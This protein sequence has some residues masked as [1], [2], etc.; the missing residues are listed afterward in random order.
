MGGAQHPAKTPRWWEGVLPPNTP[1]PRSGA[2]GASNL[3]TSL[4]K[5]INTPLVTDVLEYFWGVHPDFFRKLSGCIRC[6]NTRFALSKYSLTLVFNVGLV[7]IC[8]K[9]LNSIDAF[10]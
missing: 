10:H 6:A 7:Y 9:S 8:Q 2:S 1:L 3:A 4:H 5:I